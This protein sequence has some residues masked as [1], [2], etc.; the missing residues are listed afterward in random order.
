MYDLKSTQLWKQFPGI[1]QGSVRQSGSP[2]ILTM[3][4]LLSTKAKEVWVCRG[5]KLDVYWYEMTNLTLFYSLSCTLS[6]CFTISLHIWADSNQLNFCCTV[7]TL[8]WKQSKQTSLNLMFFACFLGSF[9]FILQNSVMFRVT[10][11]LSENT[12]SHMLSSE[13]CHRFFFVCYFLYETIGVVTQKQTGLIIIL[14][15]WQRGH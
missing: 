11:F 9:F 5:L 15:Q 2:L 3:L 1:N 8:T 13:Q 7:C 14:I 10:V 6:P 4:F 12:N